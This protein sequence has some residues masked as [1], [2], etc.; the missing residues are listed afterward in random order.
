MKVRNIATEM[1]IIV[2]ALAVGTYSQYAALVNRY[3][4]NADAPQAISWLQRFRDPALF[5]NDLLSEA[6]EQMHGQIGFVY[7]YR[8]FA[9]WVDP[10]TLS[11]IVPIFLLAAF[12]L[13]TYRF[14]SQ[15]GTPFTAL[16]TAG[17]AIV[18]PMYLEI[19]SG[20][21]QRAFALPLMMAFLYYVTIKAWRRAG[22]SLALQALFYPMGF[23]LSAPT[24]ALV[25]LNELRRS[26]WARTRAPLV[27]LALIA[28]ACSTLLAVK[29]VYAP[30]SRIG[31][32]ITRP[33]MAGRPEF[34]VS[35]RAQILPSIGLPRE[36]VDQVVGAVRSL[37]LGY[38][39]AL[40]HVSRTSP[41]A[42]FVIVPGVLA[43]LALAV[44]LIVRGVVR[45]MFCVP[46]VLVFFV[47]S[48]AVLYLVAEQVLFRLY[49]PSR[50]LTYPVQI[51]GLIMTGLAIGFVIESID[52]THLRRAVQVALLLLIA[53]RLDLT[54]NIGLSDESA[55]RPL[56]EF[57][58]TLPRDAMIASHPHVA[59]YIPTFAHRKVFV[60]FEQSYPWFDAYWGTISR[61]TTTLF[62]AYYAPTREEIY[63]FCEANGVDY[64]VV[65]KRDFDPAYLSTHR[66]YFEPFER[67]VRGRLSSSHGHA[68]AQV[69]DDEMLFRS[70]DTFVISKESLIGKMTP[71]QQ[72]LSIAE[73]SGGVATTIRG[74]T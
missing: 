19:M 36:A 65:R 68:L 33:E 51:S 20:G 1:A 5:Q 63:E 74:R 50:Y 34:L 12:A 14:V 69:A 7:F 39:A 13:Y 26:G 70:G 41:V 54:R 47:T 8:A 46:P 44:I 30:D 66:I 73:P 11:K 29:N 32:I 62:D 9:T 42:G 48:G 4:V 57:L 31:R 58:E 3:V 18:A 40:L 38:P 55:D 24:G 61:R 16:V 43:V 2:W 25:L 22:V 53:L 60:N 52:K 35:G 10:L 37:S 64:L 6:A 21:H 28:V 49:L 15:F 72:K 23:L 59:D 71:A 67:Y 17:L 56:F 45:R 27:G